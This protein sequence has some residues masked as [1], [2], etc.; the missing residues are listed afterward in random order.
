MSEVLPSLVRA[1]VAVIEDADLDAAGARAGL[2]AIERAMRGEHERVP[3][4]EYAAMLNR[5]GAR[6]SPVEQ[7]LLGERYT[8]F[9]SEF[10][11]LAQLAMSPERLFR[12]TLGTLHVTWPHARFEHAWVGD[13]EVTLDV[14]VPPPYLP[15]PIWLR[16]SVGVFRALPRSMGLPDAEVEHDLGERG[17]QFRVHVPSSGTLV[18]RARRA[19]DAREL[20]LLVEHLLDAI[21]EPPRPSIG[22]VPDVLTLQ[23][24]WGLTRM[25]A[26]VARRLATGMRL[27]DVARDLGISQETARTHLKQLFSKTETNRQVAL[28]ALLR[29]LPL[30]RSE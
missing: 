6:L 27:K 1:F 21:V 2:P 10:R 24:A 13:R 17:G 5:V 25:E 19:V 9:V 3:W 14:E 8:E 26:R 18:A 15:C 29:G 23:R 16:A 22:V 20:S 11:A 28:V 4:D 12:V 7:E 30:D